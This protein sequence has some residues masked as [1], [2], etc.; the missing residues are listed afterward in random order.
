MIG[1]TVKITD[2]TSRVKKAVDKAAFK[3]YAHG[4]ASVR[5]EAIDSV[6]ITK[7]TIGWITTNRRTKRGKRR[8]ARIYKPSPVGTPVHSHRNKGFVRRGIRFDATKEDAVIGFAHTVYGDVMEVHEKGG[9][10]FG[11]HFDP[12]PVMA[13]ALE[14]AAPRFAESWRG[15]IGE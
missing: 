9:E 13:P 5:K 12:R 14:Q 2:L 15:S 10:R 11:Q 7:E 3:S 1:M 6:E 4:A 8:R